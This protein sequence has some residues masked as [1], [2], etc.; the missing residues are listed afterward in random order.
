[1][2]THFSWVHAVLGSQG[3]EKQQ[4]E[5]QYVFYSAFAVLQLALMTTH[6][7]ANRHMGNSCGNMTFNNLSIYQSLNRR[8]AMVGIRWYAAT[9]SC[10]TSQQQHV[11]GLGHMPLS[12]HFVCTACCI[13]FGLRGT[14]QRGCAADAINCHKGLHQSH[15][16][17]TYSPITW[18]GMPCNG[19]PAHVEHGLGCL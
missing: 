1:M 9:H 8:P 4:Q 14:R 3:T 2:N 17:S 6:S 11:T 18:L 5:V 12:G 13:P 7:H 10:H 19:Q 16:S 15:R